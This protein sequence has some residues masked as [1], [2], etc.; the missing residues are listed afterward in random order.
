MRRK[1]RHMMGMLSMTHKERLGLTILVDMG[2]DKASINLGREQKI[3]MRKRLLALGLVIVGFLLLLRLRPVDRRKEV[4]DLL[5]AEFRFCEL[6]RDEMPTK[7]LGRFWLSCNGRPFYAEL[8]NGSL[9]YELN[10]WGWLRETHYWDELQG[11]GLYSKEELSFFCYEDGI[12][13]KR[14][15]LSIPDFELEKVGEG[16]FIPVLVLSLEKRFP[17]LSECELASYE[18]VGIAPLFNLTFDCK[19][20]SY[21]VL[22]D[23]DFVFLLPS[24]LDE[25]SL[26]RSF[27]LAF[28]RE[29]E[30]EDQ[31]VK[32][33]FDGFTLS[34][35]YN[36]ERLGLLVKDFKD[37]KQILRDLA[38]LLLLDF[39]PNDIVYVGER[40]GVAGRI[41]V[42]RVGDDVLMLGLDDGNVIFVQRMFEGIG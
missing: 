41:M 4:L 25:Q 3:I 31:R 37:P 30:V 34:F 20:E 32:A 28:G 7:G 33:D 23:L 11:C 38:P 36:P 42:Y 39:V 27:S 15:E 35:D 26:K 21:H 1:A 9:S 14:F 24:S 6:I 13:L 12:V 2:E 8:R 29:G 10:G 22:T 5:R 16:D 40:E 19:P 18:G 17:F